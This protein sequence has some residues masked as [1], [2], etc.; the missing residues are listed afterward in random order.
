MFY[1]RFFIFK[2]EQIPLFWWAMWANRSG[3]SP[4][5]SDGSES[6]RSLTKNEWPWVLRSGCSEEMS[7]RE[8]IA[9]ITHQ[10]WANE[11]TTRFFERITHSLIF[12]QK[13]SDSLGKPMS[14][15]P[16]LFL[17]QH[18]ALWQHGL[19]IYSRRAP[20]G[21]RVYIFIPAVRSLVTGLTYLFQQCALW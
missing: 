7:H 8:Q 17:S 3:R 9:Q 21:N 15:F 14:E 18:F 4:I 5:M 10:N 11:W 16:A 1:M 2:T 6:L 19:H 13:T 20:S 12:G